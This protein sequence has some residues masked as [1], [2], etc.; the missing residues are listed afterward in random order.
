M[1]NKDLD[2][3]LLREMFNAIRNA[4]IK[5]IKIQKKDDK[6]MVK[7]IASYITKKVEREGVH[8]D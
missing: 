3:A 5:N 1:E 8:E 7:S 2:A 6:Q 4:E